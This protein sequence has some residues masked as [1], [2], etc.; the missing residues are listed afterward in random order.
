MSRPASDRLVSKGGSLGI[1]TKKKA[2]GPNK[3][4]VIYLLTI[5]KSNAYFTNYLST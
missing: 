2:N 3:K 5:V 1:N 4:T